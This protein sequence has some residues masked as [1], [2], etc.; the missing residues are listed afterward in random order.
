MNKVQEKIKQ[1]EKTI[2]LT[3]DLNRL[4]EFGE[5]CKAKR[6]ALQIRLRKMSNDIDVPMSTISRIENGFRGSSIESYI[7]IA[8]YL[9]DYD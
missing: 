2:N 5:N 1:F 7:K 3:L 9:N 4:D 6:E 8:N